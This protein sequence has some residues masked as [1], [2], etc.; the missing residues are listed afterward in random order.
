MKSSG[1]NVK[2]KWLAPLGLTLIGAGMSITGE[3]I[4]LKSE[5]VEWWKWVLSGTLGLTI[6]NSG[7]AIFGEAVKLSTLNTWYENEHTS[8]SN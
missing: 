1:K 4:I 7:I 8:Q 3:A 2:W 5:A 6:L